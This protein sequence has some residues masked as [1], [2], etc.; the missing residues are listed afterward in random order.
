VVDSLERDAAVP[1][2]ARIGRAPLVAAIAIVVATPVL[3]ALADHI[4]GTVPFF[5]P[6]F[7]ATVWVLDLLT[8][9][10][11]ITQYLAGASPR[12]LVLSLAYLWSSAVIVPH[13]LVFSGLFAPAGLLGAV[14]SSAPWLWAAWH[15]GFPLFIGLALA[16]WPRR[17]YEWLKR[18][19]RRA[20]AVGVAC[21][22]VIAAVVLVAALVT[23][24]HEHIPTIIAG[25]DYSILTRR[26]GVW[27]IGVN[28][29]ALGL[30]ATTFR[31]PARGLE[32]WA[33]VAVAASC[34]DALLTLYARSRFTVGWYGARVLALVAAMVVLTSLL[35]EITVLY[36]RVRRSAE[37]LARRN[38]ELIDANAVR[39]HLVAVVSHEL[40]TP[41]TA[42]AGITEIL[43]D[44]R[45]VLPPGKMDDLLRRST[46]LTQRMSL[47]TEDLLAV[48]TIDRGELH[49]AP[50]DVDVNVALREVA[51]TFPGADVHVRDAGGLT[52]HADPLRLQQMLANYVRNAVKYGAPPIELS[53]RA[54]GGDVEI[55][56]SDHG[57]GVPA[58]FVPRLFE[59]F[60]RA[61]Q[62]RSGA[63]PGSGLG[64]S[65]VASLAHV[66]GGRAWYDPA[67]PGATFVLSLPA[68]RADRP[69]VAY[70]LVR[71][72]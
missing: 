28:L 47:L 9:F 23:A 46:A 64:L 43:S 54:A 40:R 70:P 29:L 18:L 31:R 34:G 63:A 59:R 14:P 68:A 45:D 32:A 19:D 72:Q 56:V 50:F 39:E 10:L 20:A 66:H 4:V 35:R 24:G 62:A 15:T 49:I 44:S 12:L 16:P 42:I 65:I 33:F 58:E 22:L 60:S 41:L 6:G 51:E 13:A 26:F 61:E 38:A 67:G 55:R 30:A 17:V 71:S 57:D 3:F 7:L 2:A 5:M 48:S 27:I 1:A 37:E 69:A 21:A 8:A 11:L 36:R 25:G 52:V 53:A